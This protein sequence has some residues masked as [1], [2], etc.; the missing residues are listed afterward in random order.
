MTPTIITCAI[1]GSSDNHRQSSAVPVTPAEIAA[2]AIEAAHA[3]AAMVHLHVRHPDTGQPS[4]DLVHYRE[5]VERIADSGVD[6]ILNLTTGYGAR[7]VPGDEEFRVAHPDCNFT[8]PSARTTHIT[9][10]RPEVCSLDVATFNFGRDAFINTPAIVTAM[11]ADIVAAHVLPELEVF[12]VGHLLL[13]RHL[14]ET[15]VLPAP[16]HF[17][18]CLGIK[19]AM[20]ATASAVDFMVDLL[21]PGATWSAFGV[22][23]SQFPMAAIAVAAGG[24]VRVGLEDNLYLSKGCLAPS[25][26]SLVERAVH[27][28]EALG[29]TVATPSQAR[30]ILHL[31]PKDQ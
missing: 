26:A 10:L 2:S 7:F 19:W 31:S 12:E 11:A 20:P 16:G 18:F 30:S 5:V 9:E 1:T 6:V 14:I 13:A 25:N 17:Q 21:P 15:G 28:I 24:H 22:G 27:V 4:T 3:G 29:A 8:T 23:A